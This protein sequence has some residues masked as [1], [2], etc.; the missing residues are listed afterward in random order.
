MKYRMFVFL[1]VFVF[2]LL[3][4]P[5]V[6]SQAKMSNSIILINKKITIEIGSKKKLIVKTR[7]KNNRWKSSNKKVVTVSKN[8]VIKAKKR[9]KARIT[10]SNMFG[11]ATCMVTVVNKKN[12]KKS[13]SS[14]TANKENEN[15]VLMPSFEPEKAQEPKETPGTINYDSNITGEPSNQNPPIVLP[16]E[17][18]NNGNTGGSQHSPGRISLCFKESI[19]VETLYTIMDGI[20]I[21]SVYDYW[22]DYYDWYKNENN[23]DQ[24]KL[25]MAKEKVGKNYYVVLKDKSDENLYNIIDLLKENPMVISA[26][27]IR[28]D[29]PN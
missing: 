14:D 15:N 5:S 7:G 21:E 16:D 9:G 28:A 2:S 27:V 25:E 3:L 22:K 24:E 1:M 23:V 10:V 11:K 26:D 4:V 6:K 12:N 29:Y 18:Y 8:G 13:D 17:G 19:D 20:E